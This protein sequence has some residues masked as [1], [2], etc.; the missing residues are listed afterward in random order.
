[1]VV[2]G[3]LE[4][5]L[6]AFSNRLLTRVSS[7]AQRRPGTRALV[8]TAPFGHHLPHSGLPQVLAHREAPRSSARC[9][10][11]P[12]TLTSVSLHLDVLLRDLSQP[13]SS[14]SWPL[15]PYSHGSVDRVRTQG[16]LGLRG[17]LCLV[18]TLGNGWD[19]LFSLGKSRGTTS[20]GHQRA[21]VRG[22]RRQ[23]GAETSGR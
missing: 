10:L 14:I 6:S 3:L 16:D 21:A 7:P 20:S 12:G 8:R 23:P 18:P 15:L 1:M 9:S 11:A 4:E 19:R 17:F 5:I 13:Y 2:V 22:T